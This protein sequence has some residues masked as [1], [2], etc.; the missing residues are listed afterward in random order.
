[1]TRVANAAPVELDHLI[2]GRSVSTRRLLVK[3]LLKTHKHLANL[4]LCAKVGLVANREMD[5][6]LRSATVALLMDDI[7][8]AFQFLHQ[9][10]LE[11]E[12]RRCA[13]KL[14][15]ASNEKDPINLHAEMQAVY[16]RGP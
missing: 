3:K 11:R 16:E 4:F 6:L 1:M 7:V 15:G 10:A 8:T 9:S 2:G 12:R 5:S 14:E 13:M